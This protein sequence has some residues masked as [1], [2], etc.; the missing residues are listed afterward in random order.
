MKSGIISNHELDPLWGTRL[1]GIRFDANHVGACFELFWTTGEEKQFASLHF[2]GIHYTRFEFNTLAEHEVVEL[3][4]I[5]A[6]SCVL[7][8]RLFGELSNGTF[9]VV[10]V[11]FRV[12]QKDAH[13]AA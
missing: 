5:E 6:E 3:I 13:H 10:C 4:S 11:G 8:I 2:E 9:E 7:G 12:S 1:L